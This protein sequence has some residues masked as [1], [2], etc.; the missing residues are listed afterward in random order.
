M[1]D[2]W[3]RPTSN[4]DPSSIWSNEANAYDDNIATYAE[5]TS[6]QGGYLELILSSI[7]CDKVRLYAVSPTPGGDVDPDILIDVYY[8]GAWHNIKDGTITKDTWVEVSIGS[9]QI[10]TKA[11]VSGNT[12]FNVELKEFNFNSILEP[13]VTTQDPT[14]ILSTTATGNGNILHIGDSA[15]TVRGFKYGLI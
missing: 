4:S 11:R 15:V 13:L 8:S 10:V 6:D 3:V 7:I 14:D 1:A 9:T 12:G 2:N 5:T